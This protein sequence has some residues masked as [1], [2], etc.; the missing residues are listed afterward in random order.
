MKKLKIECMDVLEI[1][2][3]FSIQTDQNS[4]KILTNWFGDLISVTSGVCKS[5]LC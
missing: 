3:K 5:K 4:S 2:A 1:I